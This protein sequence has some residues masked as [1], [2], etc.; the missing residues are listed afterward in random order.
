[1]SGP[2]IGLLLSRVRVEEKLLIEALDRAWRRLPA[3][4]TTASWLSS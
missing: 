1:M 2:L 3:R 4:S